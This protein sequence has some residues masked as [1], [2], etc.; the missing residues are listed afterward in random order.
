MKYPGVYT[1]GQYH[2]AL[3]EVEG[4]RMYMKVRVFSGGGERGHKYGL[5]RSEFDI[6]RRLA[7]GAWWPDK[8]TTVKQFITDNL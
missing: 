1:D 4:A 5:P 3:K 8:T 7:T 6:N 2:F